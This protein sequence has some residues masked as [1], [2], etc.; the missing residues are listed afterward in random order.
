MTESDDARREIE[1]LRERTSTL[2][3]AVLRISASLDLD[4]VLAEVL[5]SARGLTAAGCG[6]I[7][8]ST[9]PARPRTSSSPASRP[10]NSMSS[11]LGP[12]GPAL[13]PRRRRANAGGTSSGSPTTA[14]RTSRL[15]PAAARPW[16]EK[17]SGCFAV[18]SWPGNVRELQNVLANLTGTGPRYGPIVPDAPAVGLPANGRRGAAADAGRG[19]R[20][21]G[22]RDGARLPG[23]PPKRRPRSRRTGR[24]PP[25]PLE[26]DCAPSDRPGST[27]AATRACR[28][29]RGS[30]PPARRRRERRNCDACTRPGGNNLPGASPRDGCD[31]R[32]PIA[33]QDRRLR[34]V[35]AGTTGGAIPGPRLC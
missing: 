7:A 16:R 27:R 5:E 26:A 34:A 17:R 19:P 32:T 9:R 8:T 33:P 35:A 11:P 18:R 1:A 23:A 2:S 30:P 4:T 13:S 3:A 15:R 6:V 20:G 24:H 31:G 29:R 25:G 10:R 14:G 12:Q 22:T 28:R 21:P